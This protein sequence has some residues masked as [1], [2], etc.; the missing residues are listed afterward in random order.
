MPICRYR[1]RLA[2]LRGV[3]GCSGGFRGVSRCSVVVCGVS[4]WGGYCGH[5]SVPIFVVVGALVG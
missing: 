4:W 3:S 5:L 1:G 2:L